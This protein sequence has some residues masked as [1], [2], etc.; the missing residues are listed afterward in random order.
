MSRVHGPQ[1]VGFHVCILVLFRSRRA[2]HAACIAFPPNIATVAYRGNADSTE[3]HFG[4]KAKPDLT[5][6]LSSPDFWFLSKGQVV[7]SYRHYEKIIKTF[8]SHVWT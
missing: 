2:W 4:C 8:G 7:I 1:M 3:M 6:T 5:L